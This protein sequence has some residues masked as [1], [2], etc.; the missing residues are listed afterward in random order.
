MFPRF[1]GKLR[2]VFKEVGRDGDWNS[3]FGVGNPAASNEVKCY[4]KAVTSE[5]L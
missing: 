1:I 5:H 2:A 4:L 3:A